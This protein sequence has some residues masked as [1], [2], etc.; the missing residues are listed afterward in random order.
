MTSPEEVK[1][2]L[3]EDFREAETKF[4]KDF[5]TSRGK[6]RNVDDKNAHLQETVKG[7]IR[8]KLPARDDRIDQNREI[9]GLLETTAH[10]FKE[11][12]AEVDRKYCWENAKCWIGIAVGGVLAVGVL[13]VVIYVATQ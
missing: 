10:E 11:K 8:D 12:T 2:L 4:T 7:L 9:S 13:L 1:K 5:S 3:R 6:A